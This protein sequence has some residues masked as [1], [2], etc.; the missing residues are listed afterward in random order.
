MNENTTEKI[1]NIIV[2][3]VQTLPK[4]GPI[5]TPITKKLKFYSLFKIATVGKI[6]EL[7]KKPKLWN[8]EERLKWYE[9]NSLSKKNIT[10][11][12]AYQEYIKEFIDGLFEIYNS[13]KMEEYI[14]KSDMSFVKKLDKNEIKCLIKYSEE[15]PDVTPEMKEKMIKMFN[16]FFG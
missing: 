8:V 10:K 9:W 5:S 16:C 11:E 1:F 7:K 3:I 14:E 2:K 15:C 6:D 12:M 13:H 4:E